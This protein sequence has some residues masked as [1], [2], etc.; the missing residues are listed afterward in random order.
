MRKIS[1]EVATLFI[2]EIICR[3]F[4]FFATRQLATMLGAT[5]FGI[6]TIGFSGLSYALLLADMGVS[7]LAMRELAKPNHERLCQ[8]KDIL[9]T[10]I[11]IALVVYCLA[12]ATIYFTIHESE[13]RIITSLFMLSIFAFT[14]LIEWVFLAERRVLPL[15]IS[16]IIS[17]GTYFL[18]IQAITN[19]NFIYSV[20]QYYATS[21]MFASLILCGVQGINFYKKSKVK[22]TTEPETT[23]I[24]STTKANFRVRFY[25]ILKNSVPIGLGGIFAQ[26]IQLYPPLALGYFTSKEAAGYFGMASKIAFLLLVFDRIFAQIFIPALSKKWITSDKKELYLILRKWLNYTVLLALAI[27][28]C[29]LPLSKFVIEIV[30]G[31]EFYDAA[32]PLSI[33]SFFV[34]ATLLNSFFSLGLVAINKEVDYLAINV[35]TGIISILLITLGAWFYRLIGVCIAVV[36]SEIIMVIFAFYKFKKKFE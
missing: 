30:Y 12:Q 7:T 35:I 10:K 3:G 20:P 4:G 33:L 16:R 5:G 2:G 29:V 14:F 9:I 24:N 6:I 28:I 32:L 1:K 15:V 19:K 25:T 11:L 22:K 27:P 26:G 21:V 13:T 34:S 8:L 23:Q 17:S 36:I 31:A 18:L